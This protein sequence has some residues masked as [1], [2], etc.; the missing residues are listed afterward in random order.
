MRISKGKK[1]EKPKCGVK[2]IN[3]TCCVLDKYHPGKHRRADGFSWMQ[4]GA[5]SFHGERCQADASHRGKHIVL[6]DGLVTYTWA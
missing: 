1:V 3:S 6:R 2:S 4:C 5:I